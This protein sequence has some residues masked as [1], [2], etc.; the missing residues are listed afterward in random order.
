MD[1]KIIVKPTDYVIDESGRVGGC[2]SFDAL[3]NDVINLNKLTKQDLISEC[4]ARWD[5]FAG[6]P[7]PSAYH[8]YRAAYD[9][10][11]AK[12]YEAPM[13]LLYTHDKQTKK[14]DDMQMGK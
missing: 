6:F 13:N 10:A 12:G 3:K 14:E 8:R 7:V 5:A 1:D 9:L 4:S 11:R 2:Y